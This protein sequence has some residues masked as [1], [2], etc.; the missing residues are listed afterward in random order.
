MAK[1]T[2]NIFISYLQCKYKALLKISGE[3]GVKTDYENMLFERGLEFKAK[4]IVKYFPSA[5]R[6]AAISVLINKM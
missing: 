4:V 5:S 3:S 6:L 1:L 2:S